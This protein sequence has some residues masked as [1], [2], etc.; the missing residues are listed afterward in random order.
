[1]LSTF[2]S[3][4]TLHG[5]ISFI[6]IINY[7]CFFLTAGRRTILDITGYGY[8]DAVPDGM[9][10]DS[11]GNLWIALMFGGT[12]SCKLFYFFLNFEIVYV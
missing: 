5:T 11:Q 8:E 7:I 6:Y 3:R 10:I 9:T 4:V 12:V 2:Y 1:M